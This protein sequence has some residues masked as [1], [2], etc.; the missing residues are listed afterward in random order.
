MY[1]DSHTATYI[2]LVLASLD[3]MHEEE[4]DTALNYL[5]TAFYYRHIVLW[6]RILKAFTFN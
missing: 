6:T 1:F 2:G 5:F 4:L 3:F